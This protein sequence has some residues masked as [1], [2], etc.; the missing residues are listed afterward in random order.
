MSSSLT[1][2]E[3]VETSFICDCEE[4]VRSACIGESFY[5]KYEGK[6][7][8]VLHF[9]SK[10]K[11]A[12]FKKAFER[13]IGA[14]DFNFRGVWFPEGVSFRGFTFDVEVDFRLS[15]FSHYA[16]FRESTFKADARF[17]K[18]SFNAVVSFH[19]ARFDS[20]AEF[21]YIPFK[22]DAHFGFVTFNA[23]VSFSSATFYAEADFGFT[24][25]NGEAHFHSTRFNAVALF[26]S[27]TFN[28][29]ENKI[30]LPSDVS[31]YSATFNALANFNA[32]TF[33]VVANFGSARFNAK[34]M[35][36][37]ATFNTEAK[38]ISAIFRKVADFNSAVFKDTV[39]FAGNE[40]RR[41]FRNQ[42]SLNL[43]YTRIVKPDHISFHT[44]S[45]RPHWFANVDARKFDFT[46]VEWR[47]SI[48]QEIEGMSNLNV[49]FPHRLLAVT[50]R[51]LAVN[52]EENHRYD[53]ASNLRYAAMDARRRESWLGFAPWRL[54]WWYWAASGYGERVFRA[55]LALLGVWM[56]FAWLYTQPNINWPY[57]NP[58]IGFAHQL[59][60]GDM[61][62]TNHNETVGPLE[63]LDALAYSAGVITL[64]KPEPR[65]ATRLRRGL[66][67][68]ET[69]LGPLQAAL[70]AL[71]IRRKFMR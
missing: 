36:A 42:S 3:L 2:E 16:D 9:P 33:Y 47:G 41:V 39:R 67:I 69:I 24:I 27:A 51:H 70:L 14:K 25:F 44:L 59:R 34:A 29:Y 54:S 52:A 35:F 50:Y 71:A 49:L 65:P 8:C 6:Q 11:S 43:Q 10:E 31:F 40:G 61:A 37:S 1:S 60:A 45:L 46:N 58:N 5:R 48:K 22:A 12:D 66:I 30:G 15:T 32:T 63:F 7:Y 4:S 28:A 64:Q 57:I 55:F 38:F 26:G 13:K 56:L 21:F 62:T 53:E 20:K 18:A 19:A 17:T 23:G 68:I